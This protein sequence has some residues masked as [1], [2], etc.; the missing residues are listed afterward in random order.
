MTNKQMKKSILTFLLLMAVA[1]S[2]SSQGKTSVT[3][4]GDSYSTYEG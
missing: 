1:T 3:I 4:F 2:A